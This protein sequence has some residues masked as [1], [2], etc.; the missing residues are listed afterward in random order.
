MRTIDADALKTRIRELCINYDNLFS[1]EAYVRI[2]EALEAMPTI[3]ED[4]KRGRWIPFSERRSDTMTLEEALD[5]IRSEFIN[6]LDKRK[7]LL[8]KIKKLQID[9]E[10]LRRDLKAYR[11]FYT[12]KN[13][14]VLL[15]TQ[16]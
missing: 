9:N 2:I 5:C 8:D 12:M 7:E 3:K 1:V 14:F 11:S 10:G 16:N 13:D 6:E 15:F 4:P